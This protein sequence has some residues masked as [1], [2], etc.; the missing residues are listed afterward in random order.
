MAREADNTAGFGGPDQCVT[1]M[2]LDMTLDEGPDP[3]HGVV[4]IIVAILR[5]IQIVLKLTRFGAIELA[6][7]WR[8]RVSPIKRP[9]FF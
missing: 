8:I 1:L 7:L 9:F 6:S 3:S 4:S 2:R 5:F